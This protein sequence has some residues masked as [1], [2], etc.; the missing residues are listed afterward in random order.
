MSLIP[1]IS[2]LVVNNEY[3]KCNHVNTY[4][5]Y[6]EACLIDEGDSFLLTGGWPSSVRTSRYS[7][8]SWLKDLDNLNT[9]RFG[10][11]CGWYSDSVGKRVRFIY[12][13]SNIDTII[14][15]LLI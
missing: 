12:E 8:D 11:A 10:H 1:K 14:V 5:L 15:W 7:R 13:K 4:I 3:E 2:I 6:S 9:A